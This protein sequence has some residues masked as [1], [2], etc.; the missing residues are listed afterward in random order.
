MRIGILAIQGDVEEH[1]EILE[2]LFVESKEVKLPEDL[3][4]ID[5][6]IIPGGE[7]TTFR[8]LL[9]RS[10]MFD[11]LLE[12]DRPIMGTCAGII[13]MARKIANEEEPHHT[14]G[15]LNIE[16]E[17]NAYGR[18][19][20]SFEAEVEYTFDGKARVAFIRAPRITKLLS[21]DV[22][23]IAKLNGEIVGVRDGKNIGLTFHPEITGDTTAHEYF[24]K[25]VES[26]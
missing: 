2:R 23:V 18:Q 14:L 15:K 4:D 9:L 6:L 20:E 13:V 22:E 26:A 17:R 21:D 19:I 25:I 10:G 8:K 7:S 1:A 24:L 5:G 16:I 11:A 3:K 12:F